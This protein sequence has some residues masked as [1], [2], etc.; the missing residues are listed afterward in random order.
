MFGRV[1]RFLPSGLLDYPTIR[2]DEHGADDEEAEAEEARPRQG[3]GGLSENTKMI[4]RGRS[5]ELKGQDEDGEENRPRMPNGIITRR[6]DEH[7]ENPAAQVD[8]GDG[9]DSNRP[10][11]EAE[12]E[13][14]GHDDETDHVVYERPFQTPHV[15]GQR[16]IQNPGEHR[17]QSVREGKKKRHRRV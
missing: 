9:V 8:W 7:T 12:E 10:T 1:I 17:Q 11:P 15:L 13:Q 3:D 4:D 2:H 14:T 16:R 6:N 5:D